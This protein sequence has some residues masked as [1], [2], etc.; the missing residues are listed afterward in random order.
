MGQAGFLTGKIPRGEVVVRE[1]LLFPYLQEEMVQTH[2]DQ[3]GMEVTEEVVVQFVVAEGV[4]VTPEEE[5][6]KVLPA[7]PEE[8]VAVLITLE[9]IHQIAK[10]YKAET[11]K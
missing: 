9:P 8:G 2:L 10:G 4:A 3:T 1:D 11:G 6:A 7:V 5:Q